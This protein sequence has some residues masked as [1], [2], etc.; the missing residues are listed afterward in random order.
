[1]ASEEGGFRKTEERGSGPTVER[2]AGGYQETEEPNEYEILIDVAYRLFDGTR[3]RDELF[4]MPYPIL[5][6]EMANERMRL[7][8]RTQEEKMADSNRKMER[9]IS[10]LM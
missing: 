9:E 5:I 4:N 8:K 2:A 6:R 3:T 7:E 10:R 1:M